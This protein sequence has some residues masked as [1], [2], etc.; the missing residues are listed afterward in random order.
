MEK[1]AE[2]RARQ[3][4]ESEVFRAA[5]KRSRFFPEQSCTAGP[6]DRGNVHHT[7]QG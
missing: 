6:S 4:L 7:I 2:A 3:R 5:S 1:R